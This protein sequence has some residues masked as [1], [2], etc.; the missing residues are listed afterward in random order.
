MEIRNVQETAAILSL[1]AFL[2]LGGMA[3]ADEAMAVSSQHQATTLYAEKSNNQARAA[4]ANTQTHHE[5]ARSELI[6]SLAT[7]AGFAAVVTPLVS[8][9]R[10]TLPS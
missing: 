3:I 4:A 6:G 8:R 7:L 9:R 1:S 10:R 5:Y 2:T